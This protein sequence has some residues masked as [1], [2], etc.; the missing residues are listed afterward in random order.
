MNMNLKEVF[1][2]CALG[3]LKIIKDYLNNGGDPNII[4]EFGL[5]LIS[6]AVENSRIEI[7]KILLERGAN[8]NIQDEFGQT[9]LLFA[10]DSSIDA[11]IRSGGEAS[12]EIINLL[13]ENGADLKIPD[14]QGRTPISIAETYNYTKMIEYLNT[15]LS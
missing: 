1:N 15:R 8:I 11:V 5:P 10:V 13:L 14:N 3:E 4:N 6:L 2:A 12:V 7:I 9:T